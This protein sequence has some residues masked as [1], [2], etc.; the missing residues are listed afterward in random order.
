MPNQATHEVV[1]AASGAAFT[2]LRVSDAPTPHAFAEVLGGAVGGWV[3]GLLP[4]VLEPATTP[5]HRKLAHSVV[6]GGALTLA[7]LAEWQAACRTEARSCVARALVLAVGSDARHRAERDALV[8]RFLAGILAGL[9]AG[10]AS[11]LLL[12]AGTAKGLPLLG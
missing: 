2:L 6:V 1:G 8:W 10:Y 11:H 7:R 9:V 3:G 5:N 4:D 12:D